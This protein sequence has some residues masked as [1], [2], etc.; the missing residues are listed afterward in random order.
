MLDD[1][2]VI[3][4]GLTAGDQVA[5][6]GSFKLREGALVAIAGALQGPQGQGQTIGKAPSDPQ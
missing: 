5:A 2:V 1:S 6:S 4:A 3:L